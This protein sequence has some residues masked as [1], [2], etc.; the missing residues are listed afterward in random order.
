M[1]RTQF[2]TVALALNILMSSSCSD[3]QPHAT[4]FSLIVDVTTSNSLGI[5]ELNAQT[6]IPLMGLEEDEDQGVVYR[7][8]IITG[9]WLNVNQELHLPPV[10]SVLLSNKFIRKDSIRAFKNQIAL[11]LNR[12]ASDTL[13]RNFSSV[14]VPIARELVRLSKSTAD[15]RILAI[16]SD[17]Q[18]HEFISFYD[19]KTANLLVSSPDRIAEI[20]QQEVPLPES[21]SGITVYLVHQPLERDILFKH[22]SRLYKHMLESRG[23]TVYVQANLLPQ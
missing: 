16:Q 23:A 15:K 11:G 2:F 7:Q 1:K 22:L 20:F 13:G 8:S 3:H 9:S 10:E 19:E 5:H 12:I 14:Y 4:E 18:E 17:L 21:L 6:L